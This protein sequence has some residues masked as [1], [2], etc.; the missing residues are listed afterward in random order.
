[1]DIRLPAPLDIYF[2]SENAHYPSAIVKCFAAN[3]VVRDER[4]TIE[5]TPAIKAGGSKPAR[6]INTSWK[7]LPYVCE[8]GRS[9]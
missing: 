8:R 3:A 5:G 2:A 6:S 9:S 7:P 1:M 4:K